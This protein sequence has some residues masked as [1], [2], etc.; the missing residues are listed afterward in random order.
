MARLLPPPP[1]TR[2]PWWEE[3]DFFMDP[4]KVQSDILQ[5]R[6]VAS[7]NFLMQEQVLVGGLDAARAVLVRQEDVL[8]GS[9]PPHL[10][11]ILGPSSIGVARGEAHDRIRAALAPAF[12]PEEVEAC[13]PQ[14]VL[15]ALCESYVQRWLA[16]GGDDGGRD[17]E[18]GQAVVVRG[19]DAQLK[20]LTFEVIC[21]MVCGL[22]LEEGPPTA[23]QQH[24]QQPD[25]D[26]L[27][28]WFTDLMAGLTFPLKID[29]PFTP[30][31]RAMDARRRITAAIAQQ[32]DRLKAEL[33]GSSGGS[34]TSSSSGSSVL[35][36]LMEAELAAEA[37][38]A[39][40]AE[41]G[42]D[43]GSG[44]VV[45]PAAALSRQELLDNFVGIL[46]AGH[47][48][49]ASSLSMLLYELA[50]HPEVLSRLAQEQAAVVAAH[51]PALS[52]GALR[53]MRYAEAVVREAWRRWPV[54]P[55]VGRVAV[56]DTT[57]AGYSLPAGTPVAVALNYLQR[58]DGRW[59]AGSDSGSRGAV[60]GGG[61]LDPDVFNPDR[62]LVEAGAGSGGSGG[63][64]LVF[65]AGKRYCLGAALATAEIKVLLAVLVRACGGGW[66]LEGRPRLEL[67]PFPVA[68]MD[69]R[70]L[71]GGGANL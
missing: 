31:G 20:R 34:G 71:L 68:R 54:V 8:E 63:A 40:A 39:T 56:Q 37:A 69:V 13:I 18:G 59:P 26:Q 14:C 67:F 1:R 35:R 5:G 10:G 25:L 33:R 60:G 4:F 30:H 36:R 28:A 51:G 66:R 3:L 58:R 55:V 12:T 42:S 29:L 49:T 19:I 2:R 65:G 16:A 45:A 9:V 7:G 6:D 53:D 50:Q 57:L 23:Q 22:R 61:P 21:T 27:N 11:A 64:A 32:A 24:Q 15:Q 41:A 46:I 47:D 62:W 70:L 52:G 48:T 44:A 17:G 38:A 43:S